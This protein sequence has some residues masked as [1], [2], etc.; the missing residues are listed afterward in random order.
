MSLIGDNCTSCQEAADD[1]D[2][3]GLA[4]RWW[5]GWA[6]VRLF[7]ISVRFLKGE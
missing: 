7:K 1:P 2:G 4:G 6:T 3:G 5:R